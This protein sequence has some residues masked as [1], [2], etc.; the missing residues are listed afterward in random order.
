MTS[1]FAILGY[2]VNDGLS[3]FLQFL[4]ELRNQLGLSCSKKGWNNVE[5]GEEA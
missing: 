5:G 1:A 2:T 3:C 4:I